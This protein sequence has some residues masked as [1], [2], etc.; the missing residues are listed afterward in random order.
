M[1]PGEAEAQTNISTTDE[2]KRQKGCHN[3]SDY[4][5]IAHQGGHKGEKTIKQ[6]QMRDGM[7]V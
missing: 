3:L 1:S 6:L 7:P 5:K 4:N 2:Y